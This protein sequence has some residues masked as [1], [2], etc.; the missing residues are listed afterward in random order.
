VYDL[1][2]GGKSA[3]EHEFSTSAEPYEFDAI[4]AR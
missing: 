3:Y 4:F 2:G 1:L